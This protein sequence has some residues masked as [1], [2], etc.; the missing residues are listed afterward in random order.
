LFVI[1]PAV[2]VCRPAVI[3]CRPAMIVCPPAL[4]TVLDRGDNEE[5]Y[6]GKRM[7]EDFYNPVEAFAKL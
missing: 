5:N 1:R 6:F 4:I 7:I 2:I 3:V